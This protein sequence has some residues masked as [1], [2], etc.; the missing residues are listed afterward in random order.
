MKAE[1]RKDAEPAP[2]TDT[3][4]PPSPAKLEAESVADGINEMWGGIRATLGGI[5]PKFVG[6]VLGVALVGGLWWY[7]AR[8]S[9]RAASHQWTAFAE[10]STQADLDK[11]AA[12]NAKSLVGRVARLEQ[13]RILV[14]PD[15]ITQ[16]AGRDRERRKKAI[17]NVEKARDDFAKLADEFDDITLKGEA[18]RGA[19][20]AE[21]ALVGI[22]KDGKPDDFRGSVEKAIEFYKRLA[23]VAGEKTAAG[24]AAVKRAADLEL[25]VAEVR[26]L[27]MALHQAM[28]P[29]A[30]PDIKPPVDLKPFDPTP[31][32]T[33]SPTPPGTVVP[34]PPVIPPPPTKK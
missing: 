33:P 7:L 22:P 28:T 13:A 31:I 27:G 10:L 3:V 16:L 25:R 2:A 11:F 21:L 9:R 32:P 26:S 17:E 6:I 15:G 5:N 20:S 14:G 12:D 30:I 4:T 19:A 34:P 29:P 1:E 23:K 18:L 8:E 24:E